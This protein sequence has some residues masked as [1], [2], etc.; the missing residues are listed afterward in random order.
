MAAETPNFF[1]L[2]KYY[3]PN[4]VRPPLF[5]VSLSLSWGEKKKETK[6]CTKGPQAKKK[7]FSENFGRKEIHLGK[8]GREGKPCENCNRKAKERR[9]RRRRRRR[10]RKRKR[11][12]KEQ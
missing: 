6:V 10:R 2:Q 7:N 5:A 3:I 11:P 1:S 12:F 8:K 4:Q 9:K